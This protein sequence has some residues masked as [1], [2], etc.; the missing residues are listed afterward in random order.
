MRRPVGVKTINSLAYG[1]RADVGVPVESAASAPFAHN[2]Q[3]HVVK[4]DAY[5][6][7]DSTLDPELS[8]YWRMRMPALLI[9]ILTQ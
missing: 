3:P 9:S 6:S 5:L 2:E 7:K 1:S 8:T 4:V